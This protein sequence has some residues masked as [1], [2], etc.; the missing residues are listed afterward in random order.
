MTSHKGIERRDPISPVLRLGSA[1]S[2]A[3]TEGLTGRITV[4]DRGRDH[5][6]TVIDGAI[7]DVLFAD[8][9]MNHLRRKDPFLMHSRA[10]RLFELPRPHVIWEP[11]ADPS[12]PHEL[13]DPV[14]VVLSGVTGRRDLFDPRNLWERIPAQTLSIPGDKERVLSRLPFTR[15]EKG[16][17]S[18]LA[19]PTP[20]PMIL[21]KRGLDPRHAGALLV[22]LN[23]LGVW[24]E[25]WRPGMLPRSSVAMQILRRVRSGVG[26]A[27]VLGIAGDTSDEEIDRAFRRLSLEL[28]PDRLA[29]LPEDEA[30]V[31]REAF[32]EVNAAYGRLRRSRRSRPVRVPGAEVVARVDVHARRPDTWEQ[33]YAEAA[34]AHRGGDA[35]RARA[36]A[37]KTLGLDPPEEIRERIRR[38]LAR[39][40]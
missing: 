35:A 26:D 13:L 30:R 18:S 7:A 20:I 15:E 16:F 9:T 27:R 37:L 8:S 25:K 19:V 5:Q 36:F 4:R 24:G 6:V 1:L 40:A 39:V 38:F 14:R 12:H 10:A 3:R 34:N 17:I 28:H 11:G 21:W 22:A 32:G 29:H 23:L 31:S 2:R 33:T